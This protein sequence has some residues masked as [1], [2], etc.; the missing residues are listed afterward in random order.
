MP[1][2]SATSAGAPRCSWVKT[3]STEA[4]T[5][6]AVSTPPTTG[7]NASPAAASAAMSTA[8]S[9]VRAGRSHPG[10]ESGG[11][12]AEVRGSR[13]R[14]P[15]SEAAATARPAR[16]P[17]PTVPT[18]SASAAAASQPA[19]KLA[20]Q[21]ARGAVRP[22]AATKALGAASPSSAPA[23]VR[24]ANPAPC[25]IAPSSSTGPTMAG[26]A[27]TIP[28][29][30]SD[31]RRAASVEAPTSRGPR[32]S[33][34]TVT[35]R[36]E[37]RGVSAG[38]SGGRSGSAH[39]R[40]VRRDLPL[41]RRAHVLVRRDGRRQRRRD[42]R[43]PGPGGHARDAPLPRPRVAPWEVPVRRVLRGEGG[44]ADA[45]VVLGHG[46]TLRLLAQ[47]GPEDAANRAARA[48]PS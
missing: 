40:S 37:G 48:P 20:G 33:G 21:P 1:R 24:A 10:E 36:A 42:E 3:A 22:Y 12:L 4:R 43:L 45:G 32:T 47:N 2:R 16:S 5:G 44:T 35:T 31:Q 17:P 11:A 38:W 25:S 29:A 15:S 19:P 23:A 14:A 7:P 6:R 8:V 28:P 46:P 41:G 39:G 27:L 9:P 26:K 18:V 34:R 13:A 30:A